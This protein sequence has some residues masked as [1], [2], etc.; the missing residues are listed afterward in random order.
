MRINLTLSA[1]ARR[2]SPKG[3]G[4]RRL[5]GD[6]FY[7]RPVYGSACNSSIR[8]R[9][10]DP[11]AALGL[12]RYRGQKKVERGTVL[13][14]S[15]PGHATESSSDP[16]EPRGARTRGST[17][18]LCKL[19]FEGGSSYP[20]EPRGARTRGSTPDPQ[21]AA[22]TP[23]SRKGSDP[24]EHARTDPLLARHRCLP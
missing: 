9:V 18:N 13:A 20:E 21:R 12:V 23:G 8:S 7:W 1:R 3:V 22:R 24:G 6:L 16:R 11:L 4:P 19:H 17:P 14:H 15:Q 2:T 10:E 5:S